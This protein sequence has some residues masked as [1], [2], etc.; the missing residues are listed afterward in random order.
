MFLQYVGPDLLAQ[1]VTHKLNR[2]FIEVPPPEILGDLLHEAGF[3]LGLQL[4][5]E[6]APAL[7]GAFMERALAE[8]VDGENGRLVKVA[9]GGTK[10]AYGILGAKAQCAVAQ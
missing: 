10:Q 8:T 6:K 9:Q 1:G 2:G 4:G 5:V 3:L 7:E